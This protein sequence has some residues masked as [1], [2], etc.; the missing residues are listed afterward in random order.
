MSRS[1]R[2]KRRKRAKSRQAASRGEATSVDGLVAELQEME[3]QGRVRKAFAI[4]TLVAKHPE[5]RPEHLVN[6][7]RTRERRIDE[8]IST[9]ET[10]KAEMI[11]EDIKASHPEWM[12]LFSRGFLTALGLSGLDAGDLGAYAPDDARFAE[13]DQYIRTRLRDLRWLAG[14]SRLPEANPLRRAAVLILEAW[15]EVEEGDGDRSTYSQMRREIGRR[16]PF[17]Y[18]RLWV[19][20]LAAYYA[21]HDDR[22]AAC[23]DRIPPDSGVGRLA[24]VLR[25]IL[26]GRTPASAAG[27]E[28][29]RA[30]Q[31]VTL[32]QALAG[33]Q[34]L[35]DDERHLEAVRAMERVLEDPVLFDRPG[36]RVDL[37]GGFLFVLE[38]AAGESTLLA[39]M[40]SWRVHDPRKQEMVLRMIHLMHDDEPDDWEAHLRRHGKH[41]PDLEKALAYNR[42]AECA[43]SQG[44]EPWAPWD[45]M[46]DTDPDDELE[47][48]ERYWGKS[49]DC[50]PLRETYQSWYE[51]AESRGIKKAENVLEQWHRDF[52]EDE[53]PLLRLVASC[54]KRRVY[55]KAGG[56]LNRLEA[57]ARGR[58]EVEAVRHFLAADQ[59]A[60]YC[61]KGRPARAHEALQA[62]PDHAEP[63]VIALRETLRWVAHGAGGQPDD[64]GVRSLEA[65]KR[66][67]SMMMI[68][69][70]FSTRHLKGN[71]RDLVLPHSVR[72]QL[73]D[74]D[75][76]VAD[77]HTLTKVRD[78]SWGFDFDCGCSAELEEAFLK[79]SVDSRVLR[80]C[81]EFLQRQEANPDSTLLRRTLSWPLTANGIRRKDEQLAVFLAYRARLLAGSLNVFLAHLSGGND[82]SR[83]R[84]N[85]CLAAAH[86]VASAN[87]RLS[88]VGL[89]ETLASAH[90]SDDYLAAAE[91]LTPGRLDKLVKREA[92]CVSEPA[93]D[94]GGILR[95]LTRG[96][97]RQSR[98]GTPSL[99]DLSGV[100]ADDGQLDLW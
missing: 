88:D 48:A 84:A 78:A 76:V 100:L 2:L 30:T 26:A 58:P 43:L 14:N 39:G 87:G 18:W 53:Y 3:R 63:F 86:K 79:T 44:P 25:D 17:L 96:K 85:D 50:C 74:A 42:M 22:A 5:C 20:A 41:M 45:M 54:R 37:G 31:G 73:S 67:V 94:P 99:P 69:H 47:S 49:L 19:E 91:K 72:T 52:P 62:V 36:L 59:A 64:P 33:V 6:V 82:P 12:N 16:S 89:V 57:V 77:F 93:S 51:N 35:L 11:V 24:A 90:G 38:N 75:T 70:Q 66:P 40:R 7:V 95:G 65:M 27:I 56:F 21:H 71:H 23:L 32:F 28:V 9:G 60:T 97:R 55:T 10:R 4:G 68:C 80:E 46:G 81:L 13:V 83:R 92:R 15:R 1:S 8:M 61:A 98:T 29:A 34:Q